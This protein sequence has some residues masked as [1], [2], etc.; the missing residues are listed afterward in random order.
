MWREVSQCQCVLTLC[1]TGLTPLQDLSA[2]AYHKRIQTFVTDFIN[3]QVLKRHKREDIQAIIVAGEA[4][5]PAIAELSSIAVQAVRTEVV[6]VLA[7]IKPS[8]VAAHGAAVLARIT[9]QEPKL[10]VTYDGNRFQDKQYYAKN[11]ARRKMA[12]KHEEL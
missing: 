1:C 3:N 12:S 8:E 5:G 10:F 2:T 6:K 7:D 4:S 11:E 9:Q